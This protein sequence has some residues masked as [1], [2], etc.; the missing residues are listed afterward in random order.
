M[1]PRVGSSAFLLAGA[2]F[3]LVG[4]MPLLRGGRLDATFFILG[5][6]FLLLGAI[7]WKRNRST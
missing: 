1:G 2:I 4:T 7:N 5:I 3:F 6:V